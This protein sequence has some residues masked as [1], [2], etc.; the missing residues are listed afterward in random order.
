[1]ISSNMKLSLLLAVVNVFFCAITTTTTT[2]VSA[3]GPTSEDGTLVVSTS[4]EGRKSSEASQTWQ[5]IQEQED[6]LR[7][8]IRDWFSSMANR[9][10]SKLKSTNVFVVFFL[11]LKTFSF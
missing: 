2:F 6:A 10:S 5:E 4:S 8:E 7:K 9:P 11:F 1:M 3:L